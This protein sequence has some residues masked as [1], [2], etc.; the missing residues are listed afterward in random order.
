MA[1]Q[2]TYTDRK[3]V[4]RR[5]RHVWTRKYEAEKAAELLNTANPKQNVRVVNAK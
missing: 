4:R 1:Y 2:L 5:R 3:G